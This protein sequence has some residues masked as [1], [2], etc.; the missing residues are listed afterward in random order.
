M[1]K[2]ST[3]FNSVI[4]ICLET[5]KKN[6]GISFDNFGWYVM[7]WWAFETSKAS[8]LLQICYIVTNLK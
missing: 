7:V 6:V 2:K 5:F 4:Q 8:I 3:C 1:V